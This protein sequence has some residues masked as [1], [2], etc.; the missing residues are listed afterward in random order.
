MEVVAKTKG[1]KGEL[2]FSLIA[3]RPFLA[4]FGLQLLVAKI[5]RVVTAHLV[6]SPAEKTR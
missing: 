5:D 1:R 2:K 3:R 4:L 6:G